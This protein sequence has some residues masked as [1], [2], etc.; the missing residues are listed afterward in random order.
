MTDDVLLLAVHLHP[1]GV[2]FNVIA[3]RSH[4]VATLKTQLARLEGVP[5]HVQRLLVQGTVRP[6]HHTLHQCG[7]RARD[8]VE[9]RGNST[10][11]AET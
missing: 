4:T 1:S 10:P 6:D 9:L 11:L 5:V 7:L 2:R 8:V 3:H